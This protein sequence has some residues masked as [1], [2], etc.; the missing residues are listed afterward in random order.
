MKDLQGRVAVVTGGGSGI[1]LALVR[2]FL[3]RGMKVAALD[4]E[5]DSLDRAIDELRDTGEVIGVQVDVSS[6]EQMEAAGRAVL[7]RF[8]AVH[9]L[10]SNAGVESGGPIADIPMRTW[11]WNFGVNFWG[12]VH[13][14]RT[15]LPI[16][17]AQDEGHI[18]GTSS[19]GSW[20]SNAMTGMTPYVTSKAA[21]NHLLEQLHFELRARDASVGVSVLAPNMVK[22]NMPVHERNRPADVE[23]TRDNPGRRE[24]LDALV[25]ATAKFGLEPDDVAAQV[26]EAILEDRFW[27][28]PHRD[29]AVRLV[30]QRLAWIRDGIEPPA[31]GG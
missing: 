14:V 5:Q 6:A 16:I 22:T 30:E 15:F 1:G 12:A 29:D 27:I 24:F 25:D 20:V 23:D 8:G 4:I 19:V 31:R 17:E 2:A 3:D 21:L 11:E 26:V 7:D 13:A 9:V 18:V 10:C 28:L